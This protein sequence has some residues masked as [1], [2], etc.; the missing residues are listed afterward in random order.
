MKRM[1][2]DAVKKISLLSTVVILAISASVGSADAATVLSSGDETSPRTE[3]EGLSADDGAQRYKV[4]VCDWMILKRQ[5]IGEFQLARDLGCDGIEMDMGGLGRRDSFDNKMR[6]PEMVRIFRRTADSLNIEI[7][8]IAMSGF[9][10][11]SFAD[12]SSYLWLAEDCLDTMDKLGVRVAFLPLGGCGNAWP[13]SLPLRRKVVGR[14]REIGAM[15]R[16]RG[17]VIGIDTPLDAAGNRQLLSEIGDDGIRIFYKLQTAVE[18]GRDICADLRALGAGNIC[19]IHATNTDG[20]LLRDDPAIDMTAVR[21]TLDAMEWSG[22]LFVERSRDA[23]DVRNVR[24]NYGENVRY[25][26]EIFQ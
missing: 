17:K 6:D 1:K 3:D 22:W 14:L 7:G 12:K 21:C 15:A 10:G 4:G 8:A 19:A 2:S 9:Y 13:D 23:A 16:E 20:L 18:H 26:K 25:L 24:R 5:K 11:Q